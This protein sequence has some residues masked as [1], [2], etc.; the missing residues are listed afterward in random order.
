VD[1][2]HKIDLLA[3]AIDS[4]KKLISLENRKLELLGQMLKAFEYKYEKAKKAKA[5]EQ[6]NR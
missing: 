4:S 3:K 1:D 6:T 2:S 5:N